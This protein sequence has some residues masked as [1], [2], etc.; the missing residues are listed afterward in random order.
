M[1][2]IIIIIIV[3]ITFESSAQFTMGILNL[4]DTLRVFFPCENYQGDFSILIPL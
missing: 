2:I 1:M 4:E 3:L